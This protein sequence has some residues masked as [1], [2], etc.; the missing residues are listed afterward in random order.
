[1]KMV[2]FCLLLLRQNTQDLVMCK[3]QGAV[4]SHSSGGNKV[5]GH[6]A[7]IPQLLGRTSCFG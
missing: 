6:G 1:M 2:L 7:D 5:L 3:E 4:F